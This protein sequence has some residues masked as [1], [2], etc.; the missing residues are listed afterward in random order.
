[1]A[2]VS[3]TLLCRYTDAYSTL[4]VLLTFF[5]WSLTYTVPFLEPTKMVQYTFLL[6]ET[7]VIIQ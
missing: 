7:M 5:F 6:R 4:I 1:M 2:V 3:M